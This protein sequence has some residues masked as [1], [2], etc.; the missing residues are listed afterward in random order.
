MPST[1]K[2][3]TVGSNGTAIQDALEQ[4]AAE[5]AT[6][7]LA[8]AEEAE[9]EAAEAEALAAAAYARAKALRLRRQSQLLSSDVRSDSSEQEPRGSRSAS[10]ADGVAV[11]EDD[12]TPGAKTS[13]VGDDASRPRRCWPGR[14]VWARVALGLV[15]V[16]TL[17]LS[18]ASVAMVWQHRDAV[19]QRH[20]SAEFAAAARQ[21]V[22]SLI[23]LDFGHAKDDTRR[24]IDSST[25]QFRGDF[26]SHADD[27]IKVM[28]DAKVTTKGNVTATAV[29]SMS[30]N[31]AVVLVYATSVATNATGAQNQPRLWRLRVTVQKDGGQIKMSKVEFVP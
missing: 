12:E 29:Q 21:G 3:E 10:T 5:A 18:A 13:S 28:Q 20:R 1:D 19:A 30:E 23:T 27:F 17:V 24:V 11:T 4:P 9:A 22:V 2:S 26:E 6:Q 31:S 15:C 16:L 8:M 14:Q 7:A 25:G